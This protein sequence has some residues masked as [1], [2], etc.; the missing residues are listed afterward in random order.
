MNFSNFKNFYS[1]S[2]TLRFSLVPIDK[3]EETFNKNLM[4]EKD[5]ALSEKYIVVKKL[6]DK[7]HKYFIDS[8]LSSLIINGIEDYASLYF[9]NNRT[10]KENISMEDL[11][12]S[13]RKQISKTLTSDKR[14]NNM[15]SKDFIE[16][17]L[18]DFLENPEE[19]ET[20]TAF[21]GFT[22]YFTGFNENR[23]NMYTEEAKSTAVSY[24]CINDNLPRFLDNVASFAKI[25]SSLPEKILLELDEEYLGIYGIRAHDI[26]SLD[27]FSFALSQSGIERYNSI[28]GGYTCSDGTKVKGLNEHI[29]LF[30]QQLSGDDRSKRLPLLKPLYKQIL[31]DRETISFVPDKFN[32]DDELILSLNQFYKS[33]I[34]PSL[35]EVEA[36]FK[37]LN[38]FNTEGIYISAGVAVTDVSNAVFGSWNIIADSWINEYTSAN[39]M[40][41]KQNSEKYF[42]NVT[43]TYKNIKSFCI[44]DLQRLG[45][46]HT[47]NI[48]VCRK[49][50]SEYY[51]N[52][53]TELIC[54]IKSEYSKAESFLDISYSQNNEKRLCKNDSAIELIKNLLDSVKCLEKVLK[55]FTGSGKE[56]NKDE[57]FY[58]KLTVIN[59]ELS[60]LNLIYD[61]VRNHLTQKPYSKDK[62]KL[63]FDNPQFLGGW[64]KNKERDYLSVLLCKDDKYYLAVMDKHHNKSF[65]ETPD[66]N[67]K[68]C[69]KKIEYKLLPGPNKMLPKVF[70]ASSNIAYYN[71]G[72]EILE[73]RK[74]ETF[75]K[76][77]KFNLEDC[78]K[79]IDFY[80]E[81]INKHP[82][83][84]QFGFTFSDTESYKDISEFY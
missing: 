19:I 59:D 57:V 72:Q 13:M 64:D 2:K 46:L 35:G 29:N 54:N 84:S 68:E 62:I 48:G 30:N 10:E 22:T 55:S 58:G 1:I 27:Y 45:D 47:N 70:F 65:L 18:P 60:S 50:V 40:K 32:N 38:A 75:K 23:K 39:P 77:T 9:K 44:S 41:P 52:L 81:S 82:D 61:K 69:Y 25:F 33:V 15:F 49:S 56:S 37:D 26:F 8:V 3:T 16:K 67:G 79:F 31:T 5:K 7:Y 17:T 73:I 21:H 24:R 80:K 20:V 6:I 11:E 78:H 51:E 12:A 74:N 14:Y 66:P 76:G 83:W 28:I 53:I 34:E 4:L 36:L 71:P 43:K 63:N 42:E